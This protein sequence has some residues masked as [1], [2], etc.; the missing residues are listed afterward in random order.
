VP[1]SQTMSCRRPAAALGAL[2]AV[3]ALSGC[4]GGGGGSNLPSS[5]PGSLPGSLPT[6]TTTETPTTTAPAT[7]STTTPP[8]A[9]TSVTTTA[10]LTAQGA[11]A[12]SASA[13]DGGSSTPWGWIAA[14]AIL[15]ALAVAAGGWALG[16]RGGERKRW[17]AAATQALGEGRML[18]DRALG[19]LMA[20]ASANRP[21][22]WAGIAAESGQLA[23]SLGRLRDSAPGEQEGAA[24]AA[25]A[26]AAGGVGSAAAIAEA[27]PA[28]ASLD[29][30][31]ARTLRGR[32]EQLAASLEQVT[33]HAGGA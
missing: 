15:V 24:A 3:A 12:T 18:H 8:T 30:S 33:R 20:S 13:G 31:A 22:Q 2:I 7:T 10:T 28:G 19:E 16:R 11:A 32:I 14:A 29:E 27:A 1:T 21:E 5:L 25:A 17:R 23:A 26:D 9:T 4:G 6:R